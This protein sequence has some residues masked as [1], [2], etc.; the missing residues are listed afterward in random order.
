[1][2]NEE[3]PAFIKPKK[4]AEGEPI[5]SEQ[6]LAK[7]LAEAYDKIKYHEEQSEQWRSTRHSLEEKLAEMMKGRSIDLFRI[8][9]LGTFSTKEEHHPSV[10]QAN[11]DAFNAWLD[12]NQ[13]GAMSKRT[14]HPQ[15]LKAWVKRWLEEGK[16]LPSSMSHYQRTTIHFKK[17]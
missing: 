12:E 10:T 4:Q 15:T 11:Y 9:D 3:K 1:M 16:K 2:D 14:V 8:A 17:A 13:L 6:E 7:Q 5:E